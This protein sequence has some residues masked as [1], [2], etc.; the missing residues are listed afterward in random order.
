MT[1]LMSNSLGM[2]ESDTHYGKRRPG[3][4]ESGVGEEVTA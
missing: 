1:D 4:S 2:L 3:Q